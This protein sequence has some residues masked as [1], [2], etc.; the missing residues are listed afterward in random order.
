ML[1]FARRSIGLLVFLAVWE[2]LSAT[3]IVSSDYMP[4]LADIGAAI[5]DFVTSGVF[6]VNFAATVQRMLLGL[7]VAV[8]LAILIALVAA[9]YALLHRALGPITD[10]LRS[11]PPPALVPLLI[12]VL[13]I[14]PALFYFVIIFGCMWSTYV[15]ASNAL[16]TVEPVQLNT[17]R[18]YG[19]SDWQI[20]RQIRLPAAMPEIF[21]GIRLSAS[22]SLLAT[23]A[24]EM[25]LGGDGL[26]ALIYN[27]GFSLLWDDMYALM[28]IIGLL[29]IALNGV[30]SAVRYPL[31][32]WQTRYAAMG[33]AS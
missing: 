18:I 8:A 10:I 2:I 1:A 21:T 20:L 11:L 6:W 14:S 33:A 19:L 27:A 7:V 24:T 31:A 29:G 4:R 3:G 30:V 32:G 23:T 17:A 9:R 26:G 15:S 5:W 28:F 22:I 25:L 16:S 13:G 12:F